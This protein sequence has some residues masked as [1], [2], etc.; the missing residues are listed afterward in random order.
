MIRSKQLRELI[1][2]LDKTGLPYEVRPGRK[3][4]L[5]FIAGRLALTLH[6]GSNGPAD[7]LQNDIRNIRHAVRDYHDRNASRGR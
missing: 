7:R 1:P 6:H 4:I 2:H 5:V 3:H